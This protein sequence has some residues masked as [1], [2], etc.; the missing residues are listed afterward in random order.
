MAKD[1][2]Q[3]FIEFTF[4]LMVLKIQYAFLSKLVAENEMMLEAIILVKHSF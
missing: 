3:F 4:P 1:Y 2:T